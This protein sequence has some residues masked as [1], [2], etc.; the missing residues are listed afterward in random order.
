M[1]TEKKA[2][3]PFEM[4]NAKRSMAKI[5]PDTS[6]QPEKEDEWSILDCELTFIGKKEREVIL[7]REDRTSEQYK[8]K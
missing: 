5:T 2:N 6:L 1:P 7:R 8:M 3:N 4:M